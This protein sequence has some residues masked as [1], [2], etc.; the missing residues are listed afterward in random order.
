M[1]CCLRLSELV[2]MHKDLDTLY[3]KVHMNKLLAEAMTQIQ[4][5]AWS[6]EMTEGTGQSSPSRPSSDP[7]VTAAL[8][9]PA[10]QSSDILKYPSLVSEPVNSEQQAG[11]HQISSQNF[12]MAVIP[13]QNAELPI[14]TVSCSSANKCKG[15][16]ANDILC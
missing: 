3:N 7:A 9:Q 13:S 14:V 11:D 5:T 12:S 2:Q 16:P 6:L 4:N 15:H 10:S 1:I 8:T